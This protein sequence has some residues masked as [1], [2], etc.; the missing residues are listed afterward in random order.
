M[1]QYVLNRI[2]REGA[3]Q[4][5]DFEAPDEERRTWYYWKP[6]KRALEQL[7]LEGQLMVSH[8]QNFQKVYDLP[9]N[10]LPPDVD[11]TVPTAEEFSRHII[12]RVLKALGKL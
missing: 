4:S 9:E 2:R 8:R 3:L 10:I 6:A 12:L 5:K 1:K 11:M 7:F